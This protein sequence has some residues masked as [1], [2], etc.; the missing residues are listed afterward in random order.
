METSLLENGMPCQNQKQVVNSERRELEH[1]AKQVR[2]APG[3]ISCAS[4]GTTRGG[5]DKEE[6]ALANAN[7]NTPNSD[8]VKQIGPQLKLLPLNDQIRELQTIIRDK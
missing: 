3:K 6:P 1:A 8:T 2:F 4:A 7:A 5:G